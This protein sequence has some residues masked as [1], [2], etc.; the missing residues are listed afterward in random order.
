[1]G[2]ASEEGQL[3]MANPDL[4]K[5]TKLSSFP[6]EEESEVDEIKSMMKEAKDYLSSF[7]WCGTI[8]DQF[9]GIAIPGIVAVFLFQIRPTR[10]CVD[11]WIWVIVGDV[12]SAYIT[13]EDAPNPATA[14]D[15]YIGAME[16]WV[17]A[18]ESGKP[19]EDL[20]PVNVPATVENARK[21]RSRLDFLKDKILVRYKDDLMH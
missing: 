6:F 20:I 8:V 21:L 1:V 9:V 16:E 15:G 18:A 12:P 5:V 11:E 10:E 2:K 3:M 7:K 17:E 19:V 13:T 14:L 4:S